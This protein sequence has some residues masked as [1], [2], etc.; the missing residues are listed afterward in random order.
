M[1]FSVLLLIAGLVACRLVR[2]PGIVRFLSIVTFIYGAV[3]CVFFA[4]SLGFVLPINN[5]LYVDYTSMDRFYS[6][7]ANIG[8][9]LA[10]VVAII[11]VYWLTIRRL[12]RQKQRG[13]PTPP[14][15]T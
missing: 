6:I 5:K 2:R 11:L 10:A 12:R 9:L 13:A 4:I 14:P 15:A 7:A 8:V 1:I 3:L